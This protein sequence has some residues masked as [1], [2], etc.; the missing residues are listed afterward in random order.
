[1]KSDDNL[2]SMELFLYTENIKM[3]KHKY[4][5][6]HKNYE[7]FGCFVCGRRKYCNRSSYSVELCT[8]LKEL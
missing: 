8:S 5:P 4:C 1:M 3:Y 7:S 2:Y 6:N